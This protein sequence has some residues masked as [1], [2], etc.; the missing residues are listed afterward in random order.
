MFMSGPRKD[1]QTAAGPRAGGGNKPPSA[2]VRELRPVLREAVL[3]EL[4]ECEHG[5]EVRG[6]RLGESRQL[7]HGA[8]ERV[9]LELTPRLDVLQ[10]RGLVMTDALGAGDALLDRHAEGD[11]EL[12]RNALRLAHH[13]TGELPGERVLT[14]PG[15]R[16]ARQG[17]DR[18][19]SEVAPQL[20]PDL[21]ADVG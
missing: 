8:Q 7:D 3:E 11:S 6:R 9:G 21:R 19:E 5:V 12:L 2:W 18:V 16:G 17:A 20:Q 1:D 15:E 10:H 14:D 4:R 13:V